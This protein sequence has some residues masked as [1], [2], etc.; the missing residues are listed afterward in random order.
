MERRA[1]YRTVGVQHH[2]SRVNR[3]GHPFQIRY[4]PLVIV[5]KPT[6]HDLQQTHPSRMPQIC[7]KK[8]VSQ[9]QYQQHAYQQRL[10]AQ[11]AKVVHL[12][13]FRVGDYVLR[14][15]FEDGKFQLDC[16]VP[17]QKTE[18]SNK[19]MYMLQTPSG[20]VEPR[21]WN[22]THLKKYYM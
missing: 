9:H 5:S 15:T 19:G 22:A 17:F 8:E 11:R 12:R 21:L 7:Q 10:I 4:P 14:R 2:P 18:D 6:L 13:S 1:P 20:T 3:D 16:E